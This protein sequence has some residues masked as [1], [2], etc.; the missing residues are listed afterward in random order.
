MFTTQCGEDV[1]GAPDGSKCIREFVP[2]S[3][4]QCNGKLQALQHDYTEGGCDQTSHSL[5]LDRYRA[6]GL[7][8]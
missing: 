1:F 2:S 7:Q 8:A 3:A 5:D 4:V 6:K